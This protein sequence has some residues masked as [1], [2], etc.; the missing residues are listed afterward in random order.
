M[1]K[2]S[3]KEQLAETRKRQKELLTSQFMPDSTDDIFKTLEGS[4]VM[5]DS[6]PTQNEFK[7]QQMDKMLKEKMMKEG[8]FPIDVLPGQQ[9]LDKPGDFLTAEKLKA[10][11]SKPGILK[12]MFGVQVKDDKVKGDP[13]KDDSKKGGSGTKPLTTTERIKGYDTKYRLSDPNRKRAWQDATNTTTAA[14]IEGLLNTGYD[15]LM[16]KRLAK[17]AEEAYG[18][19]AKGGYITR[20]LT[21]KEMLELKL[22]ESKVAE[23]Q[24]KPSQLY[25]KIQELVASGKLKEEQ[26]EYYKAKI[27]DLDGGIFAGSDP[28]L[29]IYLEEQNKQ[30]ANQQPD[31]KK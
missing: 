31:K 30:K 28:A 3:G 22:L 13:K 19:E 11:K 17:E 4:R 24:L 26:A 21:M 14:V 25:A 10:D 20:P 23:G 2:K 7:A 8:Y 6:I 5:P 1:S 12:E 16:K 29:A 27:G 9:F 18:T 15:A